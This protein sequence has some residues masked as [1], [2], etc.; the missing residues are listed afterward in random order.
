MPNFKKNTS[1]AMKRSGFKMKGYTYPGI[2]PIE[3]EVSK[4]GKHLLEKKKTPPMEGAPGG[5]GY[6]KDGKKIKSDKSTTKKPIVKGLEKGI[7]HGLKAKLHNIPSSNIPKG[8]PVKP[9][10]SSQ[11]KKSKG[12]L[13][14]KTGFETDFPIASKVVDLHVK[15]IK[16]LAKTGKKI[17]KYF[18]Q[19]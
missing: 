17:K 7:K 5:G 19:R 10:T 13:K 16:G 9:P 14:G 2:S 6:D 11:S 15:G 12:T 1:P 3:Q 4:E 18:T 8:H